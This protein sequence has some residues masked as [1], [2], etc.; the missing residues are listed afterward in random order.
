MVLV[1]GSVSHIEIV[2]TMYVGLKGTKKFLYELLH[3]TALKRQPFRRAWKQRNSKVFIDGL[4]ISIGSV[5]RN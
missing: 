3:F 5:I 2:A 4:C 1:S